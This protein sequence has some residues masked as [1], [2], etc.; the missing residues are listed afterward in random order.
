MDLNPIGI[1]YLGGWGEAASMSGLGNVASMD[2]IYKTIKKYSLR[3]RKYIRDKW[4]KHYLFYAE[5]LL[6][7][8]DHIIA[9]KDSY[10]KNLDKNLG[11]I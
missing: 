6:D 8:E 1:K 10:L 2:E 11:I 9:A 4:R 3:D 5:T 7:S